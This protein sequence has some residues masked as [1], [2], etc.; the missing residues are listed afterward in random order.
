MGGCFYNL[1]RVDVVLGLGGGREEGI[2]GI[3]ED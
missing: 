3:F 1:G 2:V